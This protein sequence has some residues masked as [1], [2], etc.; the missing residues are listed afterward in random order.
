MCALTSVYG[1]ARAQA[2]VAPW[3]SPALC[4]GQS[5]LVTG[6][7]GHQFPSRRS[8]EGVWAGRWASVLFLSR[9]SRMRTRPLCEHS[10]GGQ[11]C[12]WGIGGWAAPGFW[13]HLLA[14]PMGLGGGLSS[15]GG[16]W[17][18]GPCTVLGFGE[19]SAVSSPLPCVCRGSDRSHLCGAGGTF[20]DC[21]SWGRRSGEDLGAES[22]Q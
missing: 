1:C 18:A 6:A 22:R 5:S 12:P 10:P 11:P 13:P 4:G 7:G 20:L 15:G 17:P 2:C 14:L 8:R 16:H 21:C 3:R 19:T 9:Q